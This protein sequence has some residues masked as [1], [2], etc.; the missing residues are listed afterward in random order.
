[1]SNTVSTTAMLIAYLRTY[2]DI[3][4]SREIF[5]ELFIEAQ[6]APRYEARYKL[7]DKIIE[8]LCFNQYL[9]VGAGFSPRGLNLS[10]EDKITYVEMDLPE[11]IKQKKQLI[12]TLSNGNPPST[13]QHMIGDALNS[14]AVLA[15]SH[16]FDPAE[17]V[18]VLCE[19]IMRYLSLNEK[20]KLANN[21]S[22]LLAVHGGVWITPDITIHGVHD[23][24]GQLSNTVSR[25]S[26]V[27]VD[28]NCFESEQHAK[29][30]FEGGGKALTL[31]LKIPLFFLLIPQGILYSQRE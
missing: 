4:N 27:N 21:I 1:M 19:G 9:E 12:E 29:R 11:I 23:Q 6:L 30:F 16:Y 20:R 13:L 28:D 10:V 14:Q 25:W 18:A 15:A 24:L 3:P 2:S 7:I 22:R 5:N 8:E 26:G 17:P 31:I